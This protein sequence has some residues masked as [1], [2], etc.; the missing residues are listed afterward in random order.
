MSA[1]PPMLL[2]RHNGEPPSHAALSRPED[3]QL[4][5]DEFAPPEEVTAETRSTRSIAVRLSAVSVTSA[6]CSVTGVQI[7]AQT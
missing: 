3:E 4:E 1:I 7:F 6:E 5:A 2:E